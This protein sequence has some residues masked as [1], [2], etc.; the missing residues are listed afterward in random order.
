MANCVN[1]NRLNRGE[2][3]G[4]EGALYTKSGEFQHLHHRDWKMKRFYFEVIK[5]GPR[6]FKKIEITTIFDTD[7]TKIAQF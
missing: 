2:N 4:E 3:R 5:Y 6:I 7:G 1:K